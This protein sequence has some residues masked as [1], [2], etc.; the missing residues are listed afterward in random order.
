MRRR[1]KGRKSPFKYI[2]K[3]KR[4]HRHVE[5]REIEME[6][7][8]IMSTAAATLLGNGIGQQ[9]R[10][11]KA[12]SEEAAAMAAEE[13]K[14]R[15]MP[16]RRPQHLQA[17]LNNAAESKEEAAAAG[18]AAAAAGAAAAAAAAESSLS[19]SMEEDSDNCDSERIVYRVKT[20][21][22]GGKVKQPQ[23]VRSVG[24]KMSVP[25][26]GSGANAASA[27][28]KGAA[29]GAERRPQRH[30]TLASPA[31]SGELSSVVLR[32]HQPQR[33]PRNKRQRHTLFAED[34]M[35]AG[36]RVGGGGGGASGGPV[37]F[38]IEAVKLEHSRRAWDRAS[39]PASVAMSSSISSA[40]GVAGAAGAAGA[41][42][43]NKKT[44][45]AAAV[46]PAARKPSISSEGSLSDYEELGV[47]AAH[48]RLEE[49]DSRDSRYIHLT[50][51]FPPPPT[52]LVMR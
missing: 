15:R 36:G 27:N 2:K 30:L 34:S 10:N 50:L 25:A 39:V 28:G 41:A 21:L 3:E 18:A 6:E 4:N 52:K 5:E 24:E 7:V 23:I 38:D 31:D 9:E 17:L 35:V 11:K 19:S 22:L 26:A 8:R 45:G 47:V 46:V 32:E 44:S 43:A 12:A 49:E 48:V 13:R 51:L 42:P 14:L 29:T 1:R 16:S 33:S 40:A 37:N 20:P